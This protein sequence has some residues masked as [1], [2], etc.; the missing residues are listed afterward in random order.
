MHNSS[1]GWL[2]PETVKDVCDKAG[3]VSKQILAVLPFNEAIEYPNDGLD[4]TGPDLFG[5][6]QVEPNVR[7]GVVLS[8][9]IPA[10]FHNGSRVIMKNKNKIFLERGTKTNRVKNP[11][12]PMSELDKQ[13]FDTY[14]EFV[15]ESRMYSAI[16]KVDTANLTNKDFST[17][18]KLFL[19]DADK[20][21]NKEYG[22]KIKELEG[23]LSLEEF[24]FM[25]VLKAAKQEAAAM[26]RPKFVEFLQRNKLNGSEN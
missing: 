17:I 6:P 12:T 26:I 15:T 20:D 10:Q 19:D 4:T 21:F 22:G 24:N 13:W 8:P 1:S 23:Q 3:V 11:P 7:E 25:K 16:S 9:V 14:M 2:A 18:L 5:L